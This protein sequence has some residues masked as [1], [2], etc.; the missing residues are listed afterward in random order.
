MSFKSDLDRFVNKTEQE[1]EDQIT[2]ILLKLNSL[3]ITRTPV[4]KGDARNAWIAT[5]GSASGSIGKG[6]SLNKANSIA[7]GAAG[8]IYWLANN[9]PYISVL[10]Y[11]GYPDPPKK[12]S[13]NKSR[14]QWDIKSS[15]GY[16]KQAPEG[17]VRISMIEIKRYID[18]GVS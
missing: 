11:G 9:N 12:G 7:A 4:D 16:S 13:W 2:A 17:M 15:G 10:E 18:R 1:L 14:H 6:D 5:L 8:K 3:V